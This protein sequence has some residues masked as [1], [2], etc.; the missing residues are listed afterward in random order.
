[1]GA[2]TVHQAQN[3]ILAF[4][5]AAGI[6]NERDETAIVDHAK[7]QLE[8]K[9]IE[10]IG[11]LYKYNLPAPLSAIKVSVGTVKDFSDCVEAGT[12]TE[13]DAAFFNPETRT[14]KIPTKPSGFYDPQIPTYIQN[15]TTLEA[16]N[17]QKGRNDW[18]AIMANRPNIVYNKTNYEVKADYLNATCLLAQL[19]PGIYQILS[20]SCVA[21]GNCKW[22]Q[23]TKKSSGLTLSQHI[24]QHFTAST[25]CQQKM[26][27]LFASE[28]GL[29]A[30]GFGT[31]AA[32]KETTWSIARDA[33]CC[34]NFSVKPGHMASSLQGTNAQSNEQLADPIL[35]SV[36][37]LGKIPTDP[38]TI[39][40]DRKSVV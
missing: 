13:L 37:A 36:N 11:E 28:H 18:A 14:F 7:N 30:S 12:L 19:V 39:Y 35:D 22:K 21:S 25:A 6:Q 4:N 29:R 3:N 8:P 16:Q 32:T 33:S 27:E 5:G 9:V 23:I 20:R 2:K 34:I 15:N 17:S 1:M 40:P 38:E 10:L 24:Q 31:N 26:I